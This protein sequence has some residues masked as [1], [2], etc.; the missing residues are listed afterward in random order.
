[1]KLAE[2]HIYQHDLPTK[3]GP[4][5][6]SG[7]T[8][9]QLDTTI[10]KL[11]SDT[12]LVGWGETCPLGS[13]YAAAHAE[14]ARA[15]LNTMAP[16][17]IGVDPT[18]LTL[19]HRRMNAALE[20]HSY[21]KAA[22][23]IAA[24]DLFGKATGR[25]VADLLG[26]AVTDKVPSYYASGIGTPEDIARMAK[27]KSAEGYRRFQ[28]KVGGRPVDV[29][30]NVIRKVWEAVGTSMRLAVDANRGWTSRDALLASASCR[31]V[32]LVI[33]QPCRTIEECVAIRSRLHHPLYLDENTENV[34]AVMQIIGAGQ[35]DGFGI[36]ISRVGGLRP[37]T[38]I[39]DMCEA[40]SMP[41]TAD[42]G[43]GG[44]IT[45]AACVH[46]G[47]TVKPE[48]F[49]GTWI[50]EPYI[51]GHYDAENSIKSV[52]GCI[53]LP[54]GPGLGITPDESLFGNPVA[55]FS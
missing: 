31:D 11:V 36:K 50:A 51:D 49:E 53:N 15:A 32:P 24:H 52:E 20:G 9:T 43:W 7:A 34:N 12:G 47:A 6:M 41:H 55:S 14:G 44:D 42:D 4:Y 19:L 48:L 17:L 8:I 40:R 21:A 30:I 1:M 28:I 46:L 29:D 22:I 37:M 45:A 26:G 5:T 3:G 54:A 25:R 16:D 13:T 2:L 35:C 33:E 27:K 23:D 38:T 39:R 18:Q 10:V